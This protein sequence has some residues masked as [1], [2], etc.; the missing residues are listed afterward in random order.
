MNKLSAKD[1]SLSCIE[2]ALPDIQSADESL[3]T[4]KFMVLRRGGSWIKLTFI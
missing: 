2:I 3:D 4:A 1:H